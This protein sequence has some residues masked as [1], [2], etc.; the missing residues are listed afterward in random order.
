MTRSARVHDGAFWYSAAEEV[1]MTAGSRQALIGLAVSDASLLRAFAEAHSQVLDLHAGWDVGA[2]RHG[3]WGLG[4]HAHGEMLVRKGPLRT[5][6]GSPTAAAPSLSAAGLI[7]QLRDVRARHLVLVAEQA[8][9]QKKL[10]EC[11]PL[12]YRDW[13]FATTGADTLGAGF[14]ERVQATLPTYAFSHKHHP[15]HDEA[16]MMLMMAALE[17]MNARDTRD[18][19]TR[20]IQRAIGVAAEELRT[21]AEDVARV[22][23]LAMLHVNGNLFVMAIG[24]PIWLARFRGTGDAARPGRLMRHDHLRALVIGDRTR[25]EVAWEELPPGL[26]AEIDGGCE[27]IQFPA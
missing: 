22:A 1:R 15:S 2:A 16:V 26:G 6:A 12:R 10:E 23:L 14:A 20:A 24:R 11:S 18:L 27:V 5:L 25:A 19:T 21:L 7:A 13:L 8:E 3:M 17:R 4:F 9:A